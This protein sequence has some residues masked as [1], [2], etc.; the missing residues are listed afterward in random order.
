MW[1]DLEALYPETGE[2]R[3]VE[4]K[5][6]RQVMSPVDYLASAIG[7]YELYHGILDY[8]QLDLPLYLAVPSYAHQ[9]ILSEVIGQIAIVVA[10]IKLLVF[11]PE[12][13][14]IVGWET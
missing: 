7:Q 2:R 12:K 14:E 3:L 6:F 5:S 8:L 10:A 13:E 4:I 11:D 9:G 1:I